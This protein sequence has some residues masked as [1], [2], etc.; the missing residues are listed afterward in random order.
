MKRWIFICL[1]TL[2]FFSCKK[3]VIT[4]DPEPLEKILIRSDKDTIT[5]YNNETQS[6][7]LWSADYWT[8]FKYTVISQPDWISVIPSTGIIVKEKYELKL[9]TSLN[10]N[11]PISREG[12]VVIFTEYGS[13]EIFIKG[14]IKENVIFDLPDSLSI[15]FFESE[16]KFKIKNQGNIHFNYN[17]RTSN[18]YITVTPSAG[19]L[20][21]DNETEITVKVNS[22]KLSTGRFYSYIF[23]DFNNDKDTLKVSIEH[24]N[25]VVTNLLAEDIVDAE[26][27]KSKDILAY[28]TTSPRMLVVNYTY[29]RS[30]DKFV[31]SNNPL[32]VSVSPDGTKAAVGFDGYISTFDLTQHK[33]L[34]SYPLTCKATDVVLAPDHTAYIFTDEQQYNPRSIDT[35]NLDAKEKIHYNVF[36]SEKK[37]F[38]LHPSGKYIYCNPPYFEKYEIKPDSIKLIGNGPNGNG[39]NFYG[40]LWIAENGKYIYTGTKDVFNSSENPNEDMIYHT[41]FSDESAMG[42]FLSLDQSIQNSEIYAILESYHD[43]NDL[44][45]LNEPRIYVY[46]SRDFTFYRI[47]ELKKYRSTDY[48]GNSV[49]YEANPRFVFCNQAGDKLFVFTKAFESELNYPW[50]LQEIKIEK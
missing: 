28:I 40:I 25:N 50:A 29:T 16:K 26:Y 11:N 6:L 31:L 15:D 7:Y 43:N 39:I 33:F 46:K 41:S 17:T 4:P 19:Y 49:N 30:F 24:N 27:C 8:G 35:K 23:F 3:E 21:V 45:R 13:K 12:K 48:L 10:I 32:C 14:I 9:T 5:I 34:K 20:A 38:R 22:D 1:S 18:D 2:L 42:C 44:H 36:I 37:D 47:Y